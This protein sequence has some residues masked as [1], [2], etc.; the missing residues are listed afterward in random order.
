MDYDDHYDYEFDYGG[1]YEPDR[2]YYGA[3]DEDGFQAAVP[4]YSHSSCDSDE[5][6]DVGLDWEQRE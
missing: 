1:E 6:T 3:E 5:D 4:S 2:G